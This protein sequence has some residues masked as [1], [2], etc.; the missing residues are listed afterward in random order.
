AVLKNLSFKIERGEYLAVVGENG[1]GKSTLIKAILG[2]AELSS[3]SVRLNE[4]VKKSDIGY[5][6]QQT[7]VQKD[8]P[9]RVDEVVISGC[10]ASRGMLPFYT[11]KE[12]RLAAYNMERLDI[13]NI[14]KRSFR[15]LSGGQQ[16]RVLLARALC[17]AKALLVLDEPAAGLDPLISSEMYS[18]LRKLNKEGMTIVMVSHDIGAAVENADK[19]LHIG[20]D[21][22]FSGSVDDY[23]SSETGKRFLGGYAK[24]FK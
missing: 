1:S 7:E 13:S 6:P 16:Q 5:L 11:S 8:F 21:V 15:E 14:R 17:S 12:K 23:L 19:I 2:L 10:L 18:L 24:Y 3:G 20:S 9:A 4:S 22:F